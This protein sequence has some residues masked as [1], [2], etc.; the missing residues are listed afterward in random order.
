M[1]SWPRR[2]RFLQA[3]AAAATA[4]A[5]AAAVYTNLPKRLYH[6]DD[7]SSTTVSFCI[8]FQPL[9]IYV[10]DRIITD[11]STYSCSVKLRF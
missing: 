4:A 6:D 2:C 3:A 10:L 8:H 11:A 9:N 1:N 7:D 5:V